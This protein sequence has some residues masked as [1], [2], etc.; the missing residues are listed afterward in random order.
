MAND[1][2]TRPWLAS[3]DPR[4]S[5]P[6]IARW[7]SLYGSPLHVYSETVLGDLA[8]GFRRFV[9]A[10]GRAVQ[11]AFAIKACPAPAVLTL[12]RRRGFLAEV[13][14][15]SEYR[16]A[17]TA[18]FAADDIHINAVAKPVQLADLA[19]QSG[20]RALHI[21]S[22]EEIERIAARAS[23]FGRTVAVHLR[24]CPDV[25]TAITA[26]LMTG[27][28]HSPFGILEAD[29]PH[30]LEQLRTRRSSLVLRGVH[31]HVGSGGK[32]AAVYPRVI[33]VMNH[34]VAAVHSAG[35]TTLREVNLGGGFISSDASY[36]S[37]S[38]D[39]TLLREIRRLPEPLAL[40]LEPGRFLV[41]HA[42]ALYCQIAAIKRKA[43]TT[44]IFLDAGYCHLMDRAVIN[45]RFPVQS[46]R[47]D[48]GDSMSV[49]IAGPLCDS[50]DVYKPWTA[51]GPIA[52][53]RECFRLPRTSQIGDVVEIGR[54]GAYVYGTGN[55]FTGLLQPA[56][57][58]VDEAGCPR[59]IRRAE[60]FADLTALEYP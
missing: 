31:V 39:Q 53:Q 17:I 21:D 33:D 45:A 43:D 24:I 23:A 60:H 48:D 15:E 54:T 9:A 7:M 25:A 58:L 26:G 52:G 27:G 2:Y 57:L 19:I 8:E 16:R 13:S 56:V 40:V 46:L 55:H 14:S 42:S 51:D 32:L 29:L 50:V 22:V 47:A 37:V 5:A 3:A 6:A 18:G 12:L 44:W 28:Q 36:S 10:C 49:R 11:V 35:F 1:T 59:L 30:A 38:G 20:C 4:I 41:E 34:V